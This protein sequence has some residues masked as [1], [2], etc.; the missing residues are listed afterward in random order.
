[1][2]RSHAR[3]RPLTVVLLVSFMISVIPS[4]AIA[5]CEALFGSPRSF[6]AGPYAR[7]AATGDFNEDGLPDLAVPVGDPF[8]SGE[9]GSAVAILLGVGGGAFAAAVEYPAGQIPSQVVT[10]DFNEDGITDL[11]VAN[12]G[13]ASDVT[14]LIGQGSGG[15]G[16]GT[17]APP[18]SIP[19][20]GSPFSLVAQDL[21]A[22]GI[23]DLAVCLNFGGAVALLRGLG[24][25]GIGNGSFSVVGSIPVPSI[26]SGLEVGDFNHD[27][28]PDLVATEFYNGALTVAFGT[29]STPLASGSFAPPAHVPV[30]GQPFDLAVADLNADSNPDLI[31]AHT[32]YLGIMVLLGSATGSFTP[33]VMLDAGNCSGVT[34]A[35]FDHD[36]NLDIATGIV[37][38]VNNGI[39]EV[40]R[41]HGD[42]TFG[43]VETHRPHRDCYAVLAE[44]LDAD[45]TTDLA[46]SEGYGS[47]VGILLGICATT[48]CPLT[49][50]D[51]DLTPNTLNL[52][53]R[54]HW[55]TGVLEPEPPASPGDIDIA[56]IRLNGTVPVD[57]SAP[58]SIGDEDDDGR[59]DLKV[60]FDRAAVEATVTEGEAVTVTVAGSIG[61]GCFEATD[62]I[63]V[64]RGRVTTPAA[65]SVL[66]DGT[67]AEVRWETPS[68]VQVQ[69]VAVLFSDDDGASWSLVAHELPNSEHY[70]WMVASAST[71]QARIA[72]VLVEETL[73][74]EYDVNGVLAI[75]D[76]FTIASSVDVPGHGLELALRPIANPSTTLAVSF[77]LSSHEPAAL[78]AYDVSGRE[79]SRR[80]VSGGGHHVVTLG[81]DVRL[82]PGTY[83]VHLIQGERRRSTRSVVIR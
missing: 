62:V 49:P 21:D 25:G 8:S 6:I 16:N 20:G 40:Y 38:G 73:L 80:E 71:D 23:T 3:T 9:T 75:S 14:I 81:T 13:G 44:D 37:T 58:T 77:T 17:F 41:G 47:A 15:S 19:V 31:V 69:S 12:K 72:V 65:G 27:G 52:R 70:D 34:T 32:D 35:D 30:L 10:G 11:A 76:R 18:V 28:V 83:F 59:P 45:G 60:K 63:R 48:P 78:V 55:V 57:P 68:G 33:G 26:S 66:Q 79:V 43:A 74:D 1:M 64:R 42:G 24:S 36:G 22:D 5:D 61:S 29:G 54:G 4:L 2:P 7:Y 39:V 56:S 67:T 46:V 53:S 82:V 51:L 50:V